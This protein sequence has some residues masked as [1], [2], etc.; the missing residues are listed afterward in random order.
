[1]AEP[2]KIRQAHLLMVEGKDEQLFFEAL[3]KHM[4][5]SSVQVLETGGKDQFRVRAAAWVS[6]SDFDNMVVSVGIVR[7][8]DNSHKSAFDSVCSG[9]KHLKLSVPSTPMAFTSE[10]PRI[11]IMVMPPT[12]VGTNRMLEDVCLASVADEAAVRCVDDYFA[13]LKSKSI[14]HANHFNAKARLHVFLAS[15]TS[16]DL[17]LGEAAQKGYWNWDHD[18]F[19]DIKTFLRTLANA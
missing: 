13:C 18:V 17:R 2:A 6:A 16:P 4:S 11:G 10:V 19:K 1:M 9:L 14:E 5:V 15:C 12:P 8:A 3:L 7:D